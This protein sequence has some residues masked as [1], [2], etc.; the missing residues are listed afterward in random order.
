[1]LQSLL[2][3]PEL[4]SIPS[5]PRQTILVS[6]F[7]LK[8]PL[9]AAANA[10]SWFLPPSPISFVGCKFTMVSP[11]KI[12]AVGLSQS[13]ILLANFESKPPNILAS[14]L[15]EEPKFSTCSPCFLKYAIIF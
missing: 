7:L 1:M 8:L 14:P 2:A 3:A 12:N 6:S 5:V 15:N 9:K 4:P 11:P 13:L 10:A